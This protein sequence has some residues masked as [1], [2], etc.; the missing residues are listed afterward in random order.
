MLDA[1]FALH[2][3]FGLP[4]LSSSPVSVDSAF[5]S[6]SWPSDFSYVPPINPPPPASALAVTRA[7]RLDHL[8]Q[9][10]QPSNP[11]ELR[12]QQIPEEDIINGVS[13]VLLCLMSRT[14]LVCRMRYDPSL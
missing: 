4:T 12:L 14:D 13:R 9:T 11:R 1:A 6:D 10:P 2:Q 8:V 7:G 5:A 3:P